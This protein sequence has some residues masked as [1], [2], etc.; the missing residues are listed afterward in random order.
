[1]QDPSTFWVRQFGSELIKTIIPFDP[2]VDPDGWLETD[3][4][5]PDDDPD[6]DE[7]EDDPEDDDPDDDDDEAPD[8]EVRHCVPESA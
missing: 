2:D 3:D 4:D 1:M 5:D 7:D 6:E 8:D